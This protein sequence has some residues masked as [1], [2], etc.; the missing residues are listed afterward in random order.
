[1]DFVQFLLD[2]YDMDYEDADSIVEECMINIRNGDLPSD[3][4]EYMQEQMEL[5]DID[6]I[7]KMME[8]M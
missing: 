1:M 2:N 4:L 6:I 5:T 8:T 3:L 7:R